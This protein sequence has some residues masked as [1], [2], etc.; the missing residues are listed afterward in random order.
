MNSETN[1][2][3]KRLESVVGGPMTDHGT[4][5]DLREPDNL[6]C[7]RTTC[8]KASFENDE[9]SPSLSVE[10]I[11]HETDVSVNKLECTPIRSLYRRIIAD[12]AP[13]YKFCARKDK[14]EY[15]RQT[16][17]EMQKAGVRF[18]KL[19]GYSSIRDQRPLT[20][21]TN[22]SIIAAR[23]VR[24]VRAACQDGSIPPGT[25][26]HMAGKVVSVASKSTFQQAPPVR[27]VNFAQKQTDDL[28]SIHEVSVEPRQQ[29]FSRSPCSYDIKEA[30]TKITVASHPL[31]NLKGGLIPTAPAI[32][33]FP[34][35]TPT[36]EGEASLQTK[37]HFFHP[38]PALNG[39]VESWSSFAQLPADLKALVDEEMDNV[40]AENFNLPGEAKRMHSEAFVH[41]VL[42]GANSICAADEVQDHQDQVKPPPFQR[43]RPSAPEP[44]S[45]ETPVWLHL[46][47]HLTVLERSHAM[48]ERRLK[49]VEEENEKLRHEQGE[50]CTLLHQ[51]QSQQGWV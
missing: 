37:E 24:C 51:Q 11:S 48:L 35:S 43:A 32:V 42:V 47:R 40:S 29:S 23:V 9:G 2:G 26:S 7:T 41:E 13:G 19:G 6:S 1:E 31:S 18:L 8:S 25:T 27:H 46:S 14:Q 12:V 20:L 49:T 30:A 34:L 22:N 5:P 45:T 15:I 17:T 39:G 44:K 16:I 3:E 33:A 10:D 36:L 4:S 50:I 38:P 28:S 21:E